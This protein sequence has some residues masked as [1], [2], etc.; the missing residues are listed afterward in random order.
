MLR[1]LT[2][3]LGAGLAR[4]APRPRLDRPHGAPCFGTKAGA[5]LAAIARA[6]GEKKARCYRE[7]S[8]KRTGAP[9]GPLRG[10]LAATPA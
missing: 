4:M 8:G 2:G 7:G 5:R 10:Q 1:R 9:F 6:V 3:P